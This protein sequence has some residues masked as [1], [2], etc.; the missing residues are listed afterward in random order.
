MSG[1]ANP[2]GNAKPVSIVDELFG[3]TSGRSSPHV[4]RLEQKADNVA[5]GAL[6]QQQRPSTAPEQHRP[7][8]APETLRS[9]SGGDQSNG[10][11]WRTR[12]Q[13]DQNSHGTLKKPVSPKRMNAFDAHF[14]NSLASPTF[15]PVQIHP[16]GS[17]TRQGLQLATS[18]HGSQ[19]AN[20]NGSPSHKGQPQSPH[21]SPHAHKGQPQ[22]PHGSPQNLKSPHTPNGSPSHTPKGSWRQNKATEHSKTLKAAEHQIRNGNINAWKATCLQ[23]RHEFT[24]RD[25]ITAL[26]VIS[27]FPSKNPGDWLFNFWPKFDN[28][29][30]LRKIFIRAE[31]LVEHASAKL[32]ADLL[33]ACSNLKEFPTCRRNYSELMDARAELYNAIADKG[34]SQ[35]A[36][37]TASELCELAKGCE[38]AGFDNHLLLTAICDEVVSTRYQ[39]P[40]L[41]DFG[42]DHFTTL[43]HALAKLGFVHKDILPTMV[44][45]L[46][47]TPMQDN[48]LAPLIWSLTI[49]LNLHQESQ[50]PIPQAMIPF[51]VKLLKDFDKNKALHTDMNLSQVCPACY[52]LPHCQMT[53]LAGECTE[54][55]KRMQAW[56]A[57]KACNF[58]KSSKFHEDVLDWMQT[59]R[60]HLP[61]K[62]IPESEKYV[63]GFNLDITLERGKEKYAIEVDGPSHFLFCT[64]RRPGNER[65]RFRILEALGWKI[66]CISKDDWK[67]AKGLYISEGARQE[68]M[69]RALSPSPSPSNRSR[70]NSQS[71]SP[72]SSSKGPSPTG[73]STPGTP[74]SSNGQSTPRTPLPVQ[75]SPKKESSPSSMYSV[76]SD[77]ELLS[78]ASTSQSG[79]E[80]DYEEEDDDDGVYDHGPDGTFGMGLGQT[81]REN[82]KPSGSTQKP[83]DGKY[84]GKD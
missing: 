29:D 54:L 16:Q 34:Q 36:N 33:T 13:G 38:A 50:L 10:K 14:S 49:L 52:F 21:G 78:R 45:T 27:N 22:S 23:K 3:T 43:F 11:S 74:G 40:K 7:R 19:A 83:D 69:K 35:V 30:T 44:A 17:L 76:E 70:S 59:N 26:E 18:P 66:E 8:P 24:L 51:L 58:P 12:K 25:C 5:Q 65:L 73:R 20:A 37:Y 72:L 60:Q 80:S 56:E 79:N 28:D 41:A 31:E 46:A 32:L 53:P 64:G 63:A 15:K 1:K 47:N 61:I 6:Q 81:S 84:N 71:P 42:I 77:Q 39:R 4:E 68:F 82:G 55:F 48:Y 62:G 9:R 57:G 67:S 2:V 75:P